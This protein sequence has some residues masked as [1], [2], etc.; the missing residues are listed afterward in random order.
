M[1][2]P[3][4][5][6]RLSA[7]LLVIGAVMASVACG[8][9]AA[10]RTTM[11]EG[12]GSSAGLAA[13][14]SAKAG[15]IPAERRTTWNPGLNAIGGIPARS[16]LCATLAP[17]GGDD[18]ARIQAALDACPA[19]QVVKL[20]PGAFRITG[21]GLSLT[22]SNITLRGSG[23]STRLLKPTG[24]SFPVVIIGHRWPGNTQ[25]TNLAADAV[26]GARTVT[27]AGNPGLQPGEIVSIDEVTDPYL[28]W[29]SP[30]SPPGDP[31]RG[32]FGRF[33]RPLGQVMEVESVSGPSVT[34]TTPFHIDFRTLN[35]AQL[36]RFGSFENGPVQPTVKLSGVE[37]LYVYGGEGGDGGGNIHLF[38]CAYCW[39]KNVESDGSVGSSA[40]LD[41][42][43]RSEIRDSYLHST[44]D[45]NPGGSGYGVVIGGY[46]ADNLVENNVVWN[47]NKVIVMRKTGGGNV[48]GYNYMEDGYGQGYPTIVEVG[49]NASHMT[50]PHMEL[51]E[52]NE[53]FNFDSDSVW[54]NSIYIT[55]YRNHLTA[56]RRSLGG[57]S[58]TDTYNRR[59]IGLT[60]NHWWYNFLGNVLGTADQALL[61]GQSGFV[62]EASDFRSSAVPMWKLGY[63]GEDA[64]V[65]QDATVVA[66][67]L[68]HGNFD[69]VS[70]G[71]VW[72]RATADHDLPP[73]LYLSSKPAFFGTSPWPWVDP[74]GTV[75]LHTLPARA[76]YDAGIQGR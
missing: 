71:V 43:F 70:G 38:A 58:L 22:R 45:P 6:R 28:T 24:T 59:A 36:V 1:P 3:H 23:M 15:L 8:G 32:W 37:D 29:W 69:F 62:Y 54:G 49:L 13:S 53:S 51:F 2:I 33:D 57:V 75:K 34:F 16:T 9:A 56:M 18:T 60:I 73:S 74:T 61:P 41:A 10:T 52:G 64:S 12:D 26:K 7:A 55:V 76:R 11:D 31:S 20:G 17:S 65:P 42:C 47:F 67:T 4:P 35:A 72:D 19:G 66:R 5:T 25:A 63:N 27:L 48:V 44:Q 46:A 21:D 14:G 50:T 39:V 30:K 40:N 68:R